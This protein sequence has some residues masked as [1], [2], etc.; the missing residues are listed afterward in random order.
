ML[1]TMQRML[2]KLTRSRRAPAQAKVIAKLAGMRQRHPWAQAVQQ[3]VD[4]A[5]RSASAAQ[6]P[7][8]D[9]EAPLL[10]STKVVKAGRP[11]LLAVTEALL[12]TRRPIS[13][14]AVQRHKWL[15]SDP[16]AHRCLSVTQSSPGGPPHSCSGALLHSQNP[17]PGHPVSPNTKMAARR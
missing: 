11:E 7:H 8:T 13:A 15:P 3:L 1:A 17:D 4:S 5:R 16:T 2:H 10:L 6:I 12:D 14:A 9:R